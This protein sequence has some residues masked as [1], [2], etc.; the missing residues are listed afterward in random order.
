MIEQRRAED[1][2]GG[3]SL[4]LLGALTL[5]VLTLALGAPLSAADGDAGPNVELIS[6]V[7]AVDVERR[8]VEVG[9]EV[10]RVP[11]EV[12]GLEGL[13]RGDVVEIAYVKKG[14]RIVVTA[15]RRMGRSEK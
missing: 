13:R 9:G 4:R 8:T 11:E 14:G 15:I 12:S 1:R 7:R 3:F 2:R 6:R 5:L 10:Y